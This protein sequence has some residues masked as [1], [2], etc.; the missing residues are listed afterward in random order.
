MKD[1]VIIYGL[2]K[3]FHE[4]MQIIDTNYEIIACTD[5]NIENIQQSKIPYPC[6]GISDLEIYNF[7]YILVVGRFYKEIL[8]YLVNDKKYIGMIKIWQY[9][10]IK[11]YPFGV[12]NFGRFYGTCQEDSMIAAYFISKGRKLSNINY[13]EIGVCE[14]VM[15]SNTYYFYERTLG[16]G[17]LVEANPEVIPA[18]ACV[19]PKDT[20]INKAVYHESGK[21]Q[22]YISNEPGLSSVRSDWCKQSVFQEFGI[23]KTIEIETIHINNVLA[24]L[25]QVDLLSIDVEGY[26]LEILKEIDYE[27]YKPE[28]IVVECNMQIDDKNYINKILEVLGVRYTLWAQTIYNMIFVLKE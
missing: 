28:V 20:I 10:P 6:I 14:P 9:E 27:K 5:T 24:M 11:L 18:I 1:R 3:M 8:N 2:G 25:E 13:C 7:D 21:V 12:P 22:F 26:D 23:R 16:K 15:S 4:D 19:R 17:I